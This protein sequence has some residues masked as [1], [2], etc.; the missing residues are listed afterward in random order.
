MEVEKNLRWVRLPKPPNTN[1]TCSLLYVGPSF[2]SY[3]LCLWPKV[4]MEAKT[5]EMDCW[6]GGRELEAKGKMKAEKEHWGGDE[7]VQK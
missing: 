7:K 4:H 2:K 3:V 1:A 5:L 6:M